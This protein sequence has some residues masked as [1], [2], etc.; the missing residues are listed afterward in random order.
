MMAGAEKDG[1]RSQQ[2]QQQQRVHHLVYMADSYA[3]LESRQHCPAAAAAAAA[4]LLAACRFYCCSND[5][6][7]DA[8]E[9]HFFSAAWLSPEDQQLFRTATIVRSAVMPPSSSAMA[10]FLKKVQGKKDPEDWRLQEFQGALLEACGQAQQTRLRVEA[11]MMMGST[12]KVAFEDPL[13][14]SRIC[15]SAAGMPS[16]SPSVASAASTIAMT[17]GNVLR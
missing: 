5:H 16:P 11:S 3:S 4:A 17:I 10:Q 13:V 8:E 7:R 1:K 9:E 14:P 2:Q 6:R 12:T 15:S